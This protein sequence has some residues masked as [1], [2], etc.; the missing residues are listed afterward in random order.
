[1][2]RHRFIVPGLGLIPMTNTTTKYMAFSASPIWNTQ[3]C[4]LAAGN[5]QLAGRDD[6]GDV[7]RDQHAAG[8]KQ[9]IQSSVDLA[10]AH[11]RRDLGCG[12]GRIIQ[13]GRDHVDPEQYEVWDLGEVLEDEHFHSSSEQEECR[14]EEPDLASP[15]ENVLQ[16]AI[17]SDLPEPL[18][19]R[20]SCLHRMHRRG[21]I[22]ERLR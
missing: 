6:V 2:P 8:D 18:P 10:L 19:C 12:K 21:H 1:M 9:S 7:S 13:D 15:D 11:G 5:S 17:V 14:H 20:P 4:P 3:L 16:A 22:P